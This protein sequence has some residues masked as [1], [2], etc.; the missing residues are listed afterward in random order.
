[1]TTVGKI[2]V[3][4]LGIHLFILLVIVVS[5]S[6]SCRRDEAKEP[7]AQ[8][9]AAPAEPEKP[10]PP[11]YQVR[12]FPEKFPRR[13]C[14]PDMKE[15]DASGAIS[16][17]AFSPGRDLVYVDDPRAWWESDFDGETDDEDDHSMHRALEP[18]F[19]RL[20]ELVAMSNATLR[21]Q[22]AYRPAT[23]HSAQS[24]HK[25]GRALDLTCPD[26]DPSVPKTN[27][28]DGK[29]VIPSQLSLEILAKLCWAAGFDWVYYEVPR[30]SG[31]HLHVS[32]RRDAVPPPAADGK[33][34][35]PAQTPPSP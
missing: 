24:L 3:A 33:A 11:V 31:A 27:P 4:V 23:I 30:S 20:V 19:R 1:M 18:A 2:I 9:E 5:G 15:S 14:M 12:P 25:E 10:A 35:P 28:R 29:Q 8:E 32:V 17:S 7:P 22:E 6:C 34:P 26:L 21:V 16:N 13:S